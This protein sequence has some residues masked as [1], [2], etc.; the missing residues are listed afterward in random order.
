MFNI[1][2]NEIEKP[3]QNLA[4]LTPNY[5][6]VMIKSPSVAADLKS[7]IGIMRPN[8]ANG[9]MLKSNSVS[10]LEKKDALVD[11]ANLP[12]NI[13]HITVNN[14]ITNNNLTANTANN[15]NNKIKLDTVGTDKSINSVN[16]NQ[17][18]CTS[19]Y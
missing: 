15:M 5:N 4:T 13:V 7:S 11:K 3:S 8:S 18:I 9:N 1:K 16:N 14:F 6:K 12:S 17:N 10:V 2:G 19:L